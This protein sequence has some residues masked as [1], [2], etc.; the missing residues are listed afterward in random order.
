MLMD[1]WRPIHFRHRTSFGKDGLARKSLRPCQ[2]SL[3]ECISR[4]LFPLRPQ[5]H[6]DQLLV[7]AGEHALVGKCRVRPDDAAAEGGAG[8]LEQVR[9][10]GLLVTLGTELGRTHL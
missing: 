7:I 3:W 8:R 2:T 4:S 10:A 9:A 1:P 6:A 5:R